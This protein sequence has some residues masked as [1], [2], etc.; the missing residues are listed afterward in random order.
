M[1]HGLTLKFVR[2]ALLSTYKMRTSLSE[3]RWRERRLSPMA[4]T[5]KF[6]KLRFLNALR[7]RGLIHRIHKVSKI[8]QTISVVRFL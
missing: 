2:F 8:D 1:W 4:S 7:F 6:I 3:V 5:E